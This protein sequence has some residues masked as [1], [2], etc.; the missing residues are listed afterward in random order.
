ML[1]TSSASTDKMHTHH[2]QRV[3]DWNEDPTYR[4]K[5]ASKGGLSSSKWNYFGAEI[6]QYGNPFKSLSRKK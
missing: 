5:V 4:Q 2:Q 6:G 3:E 1:S